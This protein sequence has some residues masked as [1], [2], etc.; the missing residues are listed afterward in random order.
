MF[1]NDSGTLQ[2]GCS[3]SECSSEQGGRWSRDHLENSTSF[4]QMHFLAKALL[5]SIFAARS[6]YVGSGGCF[7]FISVHLPFPLKTVIPGQLSFSKKL[8]SPSRM[9]PTLASERSNNPSYQSSHI[10][11]AK[12]LHT[13]SLRYKTS[14]KS[15]AT[16]LSVLQMY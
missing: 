2:E 6:Y 16:F 10:H 13:L 1:V 15:P 14:P 9:V 4:T 12:S 3:Q 7:K 5:K 11:K 8:L